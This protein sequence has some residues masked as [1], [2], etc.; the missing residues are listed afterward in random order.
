[1]S[2]LS[3][4]RPDNPHTLPSVLVA[5]Q[6]DELTLDA[7]S[8]ISHSE[9]GSSPGPRSDVSSLPVRKPSSTR[10]RPLPLILAKVPGNTLHIKQC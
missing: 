6:R 1:M 7:F 2:P 3:S 8:D 5:D 9:D 10:K 4:S